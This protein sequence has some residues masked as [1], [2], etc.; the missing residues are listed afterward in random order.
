MTDVEN[1]VYDSKKIVV[2][3]DKDDRPVSTK[4][5]YKGQAQTS[6]ALETLALTSVSIDPTT[7]TPTPTPKTTPS[8]PAFSPPEEKIKVPVQQPKQAP[9]APKIYSPPKHSSSPPPPPS[10]GSGS[11]GPGFS[12]GVAYSPYNE[13]NSCKSSSQVSQDLS[14]VNGYSVIR[15]YGTDCNQ[16]GNVVS[17][18]KSKPGIQL[19]LGIFD[20]NSI[21]SEVSTMQSALGGDW[22]LVRAVSVGNEL[23]NTGAASPGQVTSAIGTARSALRGAGYSGPVVTVD[24]MMAM[25]QHP[26]LCEASDFC[27]IN[28]HAFFDPNTLASNAGSFV[29]DW[30]QKISQ[31]AGGKPTVVTESGW[32]TQGG[33]NGMAIAGQEEHAQAIAS[34]KGAFSGGTNLIL[35]S[36]FN[37]LWKQER[38]NTFGCEKYWGLLG[39]SPS[40]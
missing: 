7:S 33:S 15:L 40:S 14:M 23:V 34:L 38:G 31:A 18:L 22:S 39:N 16:I 21:P 1:V 3:L 29:H 8:T 28:C 26:E 13:D 32:P 4:T 19:F 12:S 24:T 10:T 6:A 17:A 20:I 11:T 5:L 36:A 27:A 2:Y 37:T 25:S 30:A 9:P 35:Y